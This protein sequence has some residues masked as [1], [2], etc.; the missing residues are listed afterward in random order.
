M[1]KVSFSTKIHCKKANCNWQGTV[2]DCICYVDDRGIDVY[3]CR[4]CGLA[5]VVDLNIS[6]KKEYLVTTSEVSVIKS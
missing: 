1:K 6:G 2:N 3:T 5:L 4:D